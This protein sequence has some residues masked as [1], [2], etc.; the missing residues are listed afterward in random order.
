[1]SD[2]VRSDNWLNATYYS[3]FDNLV[4]VSCA[5]TPESY[6]ADHFVTIH[7]HA[8]VEGLNLPHFTPRLLGSAE[9]W[10]TIHLFSTSVATAPEITVSLQ[11]FLAES[12]SDSE[13]IARAVARMKALGASLVGEVENHSSISATLARFQ[14]LVEGDAGRTSNIAVK[15]QKLRAALSA[16]QDTTAAIAAKLPY[17]NQRLSAGGTTMPAGSDFYLLRYRKRVWD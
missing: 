14:A 16:G 6:A 4:T 15:I 8:V 7:H 3:C 11:R 9:L 13:I 1:V 5:Y 17:F 12:T 10:E 2:V